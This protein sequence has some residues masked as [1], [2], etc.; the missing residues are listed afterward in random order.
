MI[1]NYDFA[2]LEGMDPA[3]AHDVLVRM[4]RRCDGLV[5]RTRAAIQASKGGK[6]RPS[7]VLVARL[8]AL[9]ELRGKLGEML[10]RYPAPT[11]RAR[12]YGDPSA[13]AKS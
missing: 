5:T 8:P 13:G 12:G 4:L 10:K 7:C 9:A 1:E 3:D 6:K 11:R 2:K